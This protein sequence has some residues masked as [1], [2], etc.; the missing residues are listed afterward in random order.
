[1]RRSAR[2]D[3][4]Q[5][6]IVAVLRK[7]GASV[8]SLAAIGGGCVDLLVGYRGVNHVV[9]IKD[10]DKPPSKRRLTDDQVDWHRNWRGGAVVMLES[11]AEAAEWMGAIGGHDVSCLM[12]LR[13]IETAPNDGLILLEVEAED[14]ERRTFAAEASHRLDGMVWMITTGWTGYSPLHKG[15]RP[16]AWRPLRIGP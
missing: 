9:E 3:A 16:I 14:G 2:V 4:N 5:A 12:A 15:W 13:P 10:G 8:Q 1:M 11:A 6:A 7:M